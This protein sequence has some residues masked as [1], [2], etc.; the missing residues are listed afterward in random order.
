[1]QL[2]EAWPF[3][4]FCG[5]SCIWLYKLANAYCAARQYPKIGHVS[6]SR[7][8]TLG[9]KPLTTT[10]SL[11]LLHSSWMTPN[12]NIVLVHLCTSLGTMLPILQKYAWAQ[13]P[14][15]CV[16]CA[17]VPSALLAAGVCSWIASFSW[18]DVVW[19]DCIVARSTQTGHFP[20]KWQAERPWKKCH[21]EDVLI[22]CYDTL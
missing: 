20:A 15:R 17:L 13:N 7:G 22:H 16:V 8:F 11:D 9:L 5:P 6:L 21:K 2:T 3:A 4:N 12:L 14:P 1:M 19:V 18:A 10:A